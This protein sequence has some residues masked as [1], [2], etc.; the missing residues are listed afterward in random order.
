MILGSGSQG[1]VIKVKCFED[2]TEYAMKVVPV[3][4]MN[5]LSL[6]KQ[7]IQET[8]LLHTLSHE[9]II[10]VKDFFRVKGGKFVSV[11]EYQDAYDFETIVDDPEK[12][13]RKSKRFAD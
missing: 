13:M 6:A 10:K 5:E 9:N 4:V 7:I 3:A 8:L 11:M 2:N 12:V 1:R